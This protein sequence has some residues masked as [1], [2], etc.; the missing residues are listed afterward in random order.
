MC[1]L[2]LY[3]Q[4]TLLPHDYQNDLQAVS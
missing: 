1:L 3:M 4:D 2:K